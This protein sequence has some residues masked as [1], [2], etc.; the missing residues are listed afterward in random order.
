MLEK[1]AEE[2]PIVSKILEY[3]QLAKLKS[4][5]AD[6]L[7]VFIG[8]DGRIHGKFNQTVTATVFADLRAAGTVIFLYFKFKYPSLPHYKKRTAQNLRPGYAVRDISSA[9]KASE[10]I[11]DSEVFEPRFPVSSENDTILGWNVY[12]RDQMLFAYF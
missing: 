11:W 5:Y 7:A 12:N 8:D 10:Y 9:H 2:Y 6:G 4:T 3:R 1:L